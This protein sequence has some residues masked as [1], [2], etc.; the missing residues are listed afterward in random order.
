MFYELIF[1]HSAHLILISSIIFLFVNDHDDWKF[2]HEKGG[3]GKHVHFKDET[4]P[5][6][7]L[8]SVY[9]CLVTMS[10]VGYGD[11]TPFSGRAKMVTMYLIFTIFY[12]I[13]SSIIAM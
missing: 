11:I 9:F 3:K 7:F 4:S 13:G 1:K 2:M 6:T 12:N 10:T 5:L 8:D